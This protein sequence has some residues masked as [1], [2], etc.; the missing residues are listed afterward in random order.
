MN[1]EPGAA[2][3]PVA[4]Q[5]SLEMFRQGGARTIHNDYEAARQEGLP[6][7]VAVGPQ[8]AALL[9]KMMRQ[10]FGAG[11][12]VGGRIAL[13]FRRPVY[14]TERVAAEGRVTRVE[15]EGGKRRVHC[16]VWVANAQGERAI[17]GEASGL[18]D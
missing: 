18:V 1:L 9:F 8:V 10:C 7:P 11:W 6:A 16:E 4:K 12:V 17:V 2:L 14:V 15:P 5:L 3:P 13:T